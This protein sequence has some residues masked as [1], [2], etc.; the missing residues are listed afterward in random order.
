[1]GRWKEGIA[2][3]EKALAISPDYTLARNNLKWAKNEMA[4]KAQ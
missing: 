1:M 3:C 4:K 2:A